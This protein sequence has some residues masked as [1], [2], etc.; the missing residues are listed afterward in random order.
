MFSE[1]GNLCGEKK[2]QTKTKT[3][4]SQ[5]SALKEDKGWQSRAKCGV[6]QD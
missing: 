1:C 6:S 3:T 2:N 4:K 5:A